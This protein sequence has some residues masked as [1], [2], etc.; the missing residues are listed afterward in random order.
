MLVNCDGVWMPL[1]QLRPIRAMTTSMIPVR[2]PASRSGVMCTYFFGESDV[3]VDKRR[4]TVGPDVMAL[5]NSGV[6]AA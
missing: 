1:K 3:E 6:R 5:I 2:R 4:A